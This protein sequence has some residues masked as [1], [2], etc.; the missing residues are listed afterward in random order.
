MVL[1]RVKN[2]QW[3]AEKIDKLLASALISQIKFVSEKDFW[4][5]KRVF[6][7]YEDKEWSLT[8]C[9]CKVLMG[10]LGIPVAFSFDH[11]FRQF[12]VDVEPVL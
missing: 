5:A 8:D 2:H 11:H 9:T 12:P 10:R 7:Y 6:D 4:E 3:T 1:S